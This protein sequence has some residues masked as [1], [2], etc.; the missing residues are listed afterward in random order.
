MLTRERVWLE[1]QN[2]YEWYRIK[3]LLQGL[4]LLKSCDLM[5]MS[6][7]EL[8][9]FV[10]GRTRVW[11]WSW[12]CQRSA[13]LAFGK[14][15]RIWRKSEQGHWKLAFLLSPASLVTWYGCPSRAA[16]I[17]LYTF[18]V[19]LREKQKEEIQWQLEMLRSWLLSSTYKAGQQ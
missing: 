5:E 11:C 6:M 10:C 9:V 14:E 1:K 15:N 4:G 18:P 17:E 2:Q 16:G 19:Q 3:D 12:C 7:Q 13:R 8:C